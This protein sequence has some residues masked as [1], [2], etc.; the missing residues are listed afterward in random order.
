MQPLSVHLW[1]PSP[2]KVSHQQGPAPQVNVW[3]YINRYFLHRTVDPETC[4]LLGPVALGVQ[5]GLRLS[6]RRL[7]LTS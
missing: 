6:V 5:V 7:I 4:R 2:A 3:Q 1:Q